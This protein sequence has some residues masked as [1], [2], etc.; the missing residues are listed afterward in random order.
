MQI[1]VTN[2][3]TTSLTLDV[4]ALLYSLINPSIKASPFGPE[5]ELREKREITESRRREDE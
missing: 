5:K 1:I 3:F 4:A 2:L